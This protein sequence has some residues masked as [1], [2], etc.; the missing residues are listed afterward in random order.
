MRSNV[1]FQSSIRRRLALRV[2]TGQA[3]TGGQPPL[4]GLAADRFGIRHAYGLLTANFAL[5]AVYGLTR[6]RRGSA[7]LG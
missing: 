6:L 1:A 3:P 2:A 7:A 5:I 4:L